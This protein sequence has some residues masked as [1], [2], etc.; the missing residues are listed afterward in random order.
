[1]R[2]VIFVD[3]RITSLL[4][5]GTGYVRIKA[6]NLYLD[7]NTITYAC[8][9]DTNNFYVG[10]TGEGT[11]NPDH[12]ALSVVENLKA[13]NAYYSSSFD[14]SKVVGIISKFNNNEVNNLSV[15]PNSFVMKGYLPQTSNSLDG[16]LETIDRIV[17]SD[18][19]SEPV[20][21]PT[22][23]RDDTM[24]SVILLTVNAD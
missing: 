18:T 16:I 19:I 3:L 10:A 22:P 24:S 9:V 7:K 5:S 17:L 15:G 23:L 14:N 11:G 1:M 8:Y 12:Y 2:D 4:V 20:E 13:N 6:N 21:L